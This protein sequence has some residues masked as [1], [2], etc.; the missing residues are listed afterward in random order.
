MLTAL[1]LQLMKKTLKNAKFYASRGLQTAVSYWSGYA[2]APR[3]SVMY[4]ELTYRCTCKCAF[5]ERWKVGPQMASQELTTEEIKKLLKDAYE[6]G[7]RYVGL[8]GGEAFLRKDIFEIGKFTKSL[9]MNVTVASNGTLIN[10]KNIDEIA[11]SFDSVAISVDGFK[12]ETHD[13]LRGVS[14]VYD[15][16]LN[17]IDLLK[18]KGLPVTINMVVNNQNFIEIED[19]L[20]FFSKKGVHIQLT[21]VHDYAVSFLKVNENIKNFDLAKFN[22]E[23]ARLSLKYPFLSR[24][25]YRHVPTFLSSPKSLLKSFTCF[26]GTA[27][28]FVNPLGDVF[29]CE[30]L[31]SKMGNVRENSL[32]KIWNDATKLRRHI[33]SPERP[34]ICWTHCIVP[35]NNRLTKYIALKKGF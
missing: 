8:T 29:P 16:A 18:A 5:C 25:F 19:Y 22:Q 2:I 27:V 10:E 34:C 13:S 14:G 3:P 26:A 31:R 20:E 7:V 32:K 4:L 24:G 30:F 9:G 33:S 28:F 23:W 15:A 21:P 11:N 35:L 6:I 12:K 17:A 1:R